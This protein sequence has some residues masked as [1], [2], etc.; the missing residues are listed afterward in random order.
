M[1]DLSIPGAISKEVKEMPNVTDLPFA[2]F[3]TLP[4]DPGLVISSHTPKGTVFCCA[5]EAILCGLEKVDLPLKGRITPE[6][7]TEISR[8]AEKHHFFE[9]RVA[10]KTF[11]T[12]Y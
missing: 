3:I 9:K 2:S 4:D 12:R 11:K 6:A 5:A 7:I 8:L 10:A 1:S